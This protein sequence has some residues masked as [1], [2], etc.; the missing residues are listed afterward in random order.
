MTSNEQP[1]TT[2]V[3][4]NPFMTKDLSTPES[5]EKDW[6]PCRAKNGKLRF[7]APKGDDCCRMCPCTS[8]DELIPCAWCVGWAHYRCT[9]AIPEECITL[10]C[11][12]SLNQMIVARLNDPCV[13]A[14]WKGKQ[15]F[16]NCSHPKVNKS[17]SPTPSNIMCAFEATRVYKHAWRGAGAY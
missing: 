14:E 15:G 13:P 16:P 5:S 3:A 10:Q 2:R 7:L 1:R 4:Q 8:S 6:S 17:E 9:Y 12:R 11:V